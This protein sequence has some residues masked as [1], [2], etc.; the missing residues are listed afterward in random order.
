MHRALVVET[1]RH[2]LAQ[3]RE[4]T[5]QLTALQRLT[6]KLADARDNDAVI[7]AVIEEASATVGSTQV[8]V[9][10]VDESGETMRGIRY[11]GLND[12]LAKQFAEFPFRAGL[13]AVDALL[14]HRPIVM[15]S[16]GD[17]DQLYPSL[18]GND[19]TGTWVC[20]PLG[21]GNRDIGALALT[22]PPEAADSPSY[23]EFLM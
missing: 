4:T 10:L 5:R 1:Q 18:T 3:A 22:V 21:V 12:E 9:C 17:R 23:L 2:S 16:Q 6:A 15:H 20:L 11:H 7:D 8:T 19:F 14:Q 13:P